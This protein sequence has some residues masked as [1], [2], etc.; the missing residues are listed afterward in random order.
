[1]DLLYLFIDNSLSVIRLDDDSVT[2]LYTVDTGCYGYVEKEKLLIMSTN[3]PGSGDT[4]YHIAVFREYSSEK[5]TER[6]EKQ[7]SLLR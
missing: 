2:P 6:A 1:G 4:D 3:L 7:L 5:L